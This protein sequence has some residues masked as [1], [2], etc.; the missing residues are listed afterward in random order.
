MDRVL[1]RCAVVNL[2]LGATDFFSCLQ[3]LQVANAEYDLT[4]LSLTVY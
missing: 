1:D 3:T 2:S 4:V